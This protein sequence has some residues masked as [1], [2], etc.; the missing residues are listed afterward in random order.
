MNPL[1]RYENI[2]LRFGLLGS[3]LLCISAA[4]AL[5]EQGNM[6]MVSLSMALSMLNY[7]AGF[8]VI[9]MAARRSVD[10]RSLY[11]IPLVLLIVFVSRSYLF[12]LHQAYTGSEAGY[13]DLLS[14]TKY[15]AELLRLG[16]N[17][18]THDLIEA[19][20]VYRQPLT[21]NT[22]LLDGDFSARTAY[23]SL[24][25]LLFVPFLQFGIPT[26][27]IF[28]LFGLLT[29]VVLFIGSP[30][31]LR[32]VILLP[33]FADPNFIN[34][35]MGGVSDIVWAF[36]LCV[37]IWQWDR[38]WVRAVMYGLACAFKQLPWLLAPFLLI[39]LWKSNPDPRSRRRDLL[40]FTGISVGIFLLFN[41]P[42]MIWDLGSWFKGV[43]EPV[44]SNMI[45]YGQ[46][47]SSLTMFGY[48]VI[49]KAL[50][51]LFVIY[52]A[53]VAISLY[54]RHYQ[55]WVEAM[56]LLPG[57]ILW[58]SFRSLTSYWYF[59]TIPFALALT[60]QAIHGMDA[61]P[62]RPA[63]DWK[64]SA[65][66]LLSVPV[67]VIGSMLWFSTQPP[68]LDIS[69]TP[70]YYTN[71]NR[72]FRLTA[73]VTNQSNQVVEPRFSVQSQ[74]LQPFYWYIESG[75]NQL[76]PGES[77]HYIISTDVPIETFGI[78]E[79]ARVIVSDANNYDIRAA[80]TVAG[81]VASRYIDDIPNGEYTFWGGN[82]NPVYYWGII[83]DTLQQDPIPVV[84]NNP[85]EITLTLSQ[86]DRNR[87]WTSVML[88]VWSMFPE[89]P[90]IL[91]V[92]P[93]NGSNIPDNLVLA[94][95]LEIA[96]PDATRIWILFG[97]ENKFGQLDQGLYYW[98]RTA[99]R[100]EWSEQKIDLRQ[101]LADLGLPIPIPQHV[102][103]YNQ[104]F[105][106]SMVNI[107]LLMAAQRGTKLP[108]SGTFGAISI[109]NQTIDTHMLIQ[110][111]LANPEN[112]FL[113]RGE[114]NRAARNF[115]KSKEY[116]LDA[117]RF[118]PDSPRANFG[119]AE[120]LF[121]MNDFQ[122]AQQY[123][124]TCIT[125]GY[126]VVESY[127]GLGWSNYNLGNLDESRSAFL[128]ALTLDPTLADADLGLG[129]I[130]ATENKCSVAARYFEAAVRLN[131][132][133]RAKIDSINPCLR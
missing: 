98:M 21:F 73:S 10:R 121:W 57:V 81:E 114:Y 15:S 46:G 7:A 1:S 62:A 4:T 75:S 44:I 130:F 37:M 38:A 47:L 67:V 53:G 76:Q 123:Y 20:R 23:P 116:F 12:Q 16:E 108:A 59:F 105:P 74:G 92:K 94:Y 40:S 66:A 113:W 115:E 14:F 87:K 3:G 77:G 58:F 120:S 119:M 111:D 125:L 48:V 26:N 71:A 96:L 122:G 25:F 64:R 104:E 33:F 60:R 24:A 84:L 22:P 31:E 129:L 109:E 95:G 97:D 82:Q 112:A 101:V 32:P 35:P 56:W 36:F 42:F 63:L 90:I 41:A 65:A 80:A 55:N 85:G 28:P 5:W 9:V 19:F 131:V 132:T 83:Q 2:I 102:V 79:G 52:T 128:Q 39:R 78:H 99:P 18:Y 6:G 51:T 127:K 124:Q 93:P 106:V 100:N 70:P 61:E 45:Y 89:S 86:I 133:L 72:V 27:L 54:W 11:L 68:Q 69:V 126:R 117:L 49:P 107:R 118:A 30:R 17:P 88:D 91:H 8:T 34:Y 13:T 110:E 29:L 43:F 50:Y 103:R